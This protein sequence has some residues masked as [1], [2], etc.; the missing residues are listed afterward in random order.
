MALKR[1]RS[2]RYRIVVGL[3]VSVWI[4]LGIYG[5]VTISYRQQQ[6]EDSLQDRTQRLATL[7][8]GSLARPMYDFNELA[9]QSAVSSMA[10]DT[11]I[12]SVSVIDSEGVEIAS[13]GAP[14]IGPDQVSSATRRIVYRDH[15]RTVDLGRVSI[16]LSR[17]P[18]TAQLRVLII[19]SLIINALMALVLGLVIYLIFRSLARPFRDILESMDKLQHGDVQITLSGLKRDDEIGRMSEAVMR[20]RDAILSRRLAEDETQALLAE[21]NAVLNNALVG[22]LV[23]HQRIIVSCNS[24][25]EKLF[26]YDA[27]ELNGK[28]VRLIFDNEEIY[29][30]VG[31]EAD[32]VFAHGD[33]YS[34]ELSLRRRDGSLFP[35]ALNGRANDPKVPGGTRTWIIADVTE[36][37]RAEE[38][39]ARYRQHLESLVAERTSELVKA[40]E[41]AD[42]ANQAKGSFLAAMSH[43][44]RTPMNAIIGMSAL[45][46]KG[47]LEPKQYEYVRKVNFSARML[48]GIINDILDISKIESGRLQLEETGFDL[49]S[50]VDGVGTF[51]NPMA[52]EKGLQL[53][54]AIAADV[55][56]YLIGD[57]LRLTQILTNL[58]GNAIKFTRTGSVEV[59]CECEENAGGRANLRFS[60]SDTGI[61]MTALQQEK[62]FQPFSQ[63]DASTTRKYGG[64]G[65]GLAI[66][67]QL[68]TMMGG[69]IWVESVPGEGSKFLFVVPLKVAG[70]VWQE[71]LLAMAAHQNAGEFTLPSLPD[72]MRVLLAEDNRFNQEMVLELLGDVGVA[73]EVVENGQ[74]ALQ[75]LGERTFDLVLMDM[76]MPEMDG[77]EA[78]RR[79]R[80][81]TEWTGLP[82]VALTANA[83]VEDRERCLA[84]G[85][86]DVLTKPFETAD[87]YRVLQHYAPR[88]EVAAQAPPSQSSAASSPLPAE[89][90]P[91]QEMPASLPEL[92]GIDVPLLLQRMKGRVASCRRLLALFRDQ[93]ID[94]EQKMRSLLAAGE[95]IELHRLAHT[96]KGASGGLGA[97]RLQQ[98]AGALEAAAAAKDADAA[99]VGVSSISVALDEILDGLKS[100]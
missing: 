31:L 51:A 18:I 91:N 22:I 15:L 24:R 21:K 42:L 5:G 3:V 43:E 85:M 77:L 99:A 38:E 100:L 32:L 59:R 70:E 97:I 2:L 28:P 1:F 6:L 52:A 25:L 29:E 86:N 79:I 92:P 48:L 80:R 88:A 67:R 12:V 37:R 14:R 20:F 44:I 35:A 63:A 17:E 65:L 81:H 26:G 50:V 47:G 95:F 56:R 90:A 78:T 53:T 73:T 36:R 71:K 89:A 96:L 40:R 68:V 16:A 8:A 64:T 84:A 54:M 7:I 82:I 74:E 23:T 98:A 72:G 93:Y 19:N 4:V 34:R 10:S 57:P 46:M 9:I 61:G 66:S 39:V 75:R 58:T 55:P 27:G 41:E 87:L 13:A 30:K 49:H 69:R 94:G 33:S 83:G 76:M 60:V 45:A 62:L 11:D